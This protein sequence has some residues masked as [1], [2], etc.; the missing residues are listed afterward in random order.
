MLY[1]ELYMSYYALF[2]QSVR[3]TY[4]ARKLREKLA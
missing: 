1:I 3:D 4:L 2:A